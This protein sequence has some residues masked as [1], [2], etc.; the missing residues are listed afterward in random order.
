MELAR[1]SSFFSGAAA[2]GDWAA[3]G[4]G[5]GEGAAPS[6][7]PEGL[8]LPGVEAMALTTREATA[9]RTVGLAARPTCGVLMKTPGG[10]ALALDRPA[11]CKDRRDRPVLDTRRECPRGCHSGRAQTA[12]AHPQTPPVRIALALQHPAPPLRQPWAPDVLQT[13]R[14]GPGRRYNQCVADA[15]MPRMSGAQPQGP[16]LPR[17][18]PPPPAAAAACR[19]SRLLSRTCSQP[20]RRAAGRQLGAEQGGQQ[21]VVARR[22]GAGHLQ[23]QAPGRPDIQVRRRCRCASALLGLTRC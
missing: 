10:P 15:C 21:P 23:A 5:V 13:R 4:E 1:G 22:G 8:G 11:E 7:L 2:A 17:R 16:S 20:Q 9:G 14:N 3:A 18:L 6:L 12:A 19:H